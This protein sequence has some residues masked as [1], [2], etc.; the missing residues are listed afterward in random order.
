MAERATVF[1]GVQVGVETT[2]GTAVPA[3]KRL[4]SLSIEPSI[5]FEGASL[6]PMGNKFISVQVPNREWS[7]GKVSGKPTYNEIIY[8]F[9]GVIQKVT[10]TTPVG[11]TL[12]R[13]WA[14]SMNNASADVLQSFTIEQG[15]ATR[16]HKMTYGTFKEFGITFGRN[17]LNVTGSLFGQLVT[18]NVTMTASPTSIALVPV[19][20][21]QVSIKTAS[22]YAGLAGATALNRPLSAEWKIADR[23]APLWVLN[24]ANSSWAATVETKP[25]VTMKMKMEADAEGMA[26]LSPLRNGDT[27]FLQIECIGKIIEATTPYSLTITQACKVTNISDFSDQDGVYAVEWDFEATF[28][29]TWQ[30]AF[31]VVVINTVNAL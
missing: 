21:N 1:Q 25:K 3:N 14:F 2:A 5:K 19:A 12:A 22:T 11:A 15:D 30:K 4:G 17:D 24:A 23:I 18:D 10:P 31:E 9:C 8:P 16:A 20:P 28:D 13:Q 7:E 29:P 26:F 6:T 27:I